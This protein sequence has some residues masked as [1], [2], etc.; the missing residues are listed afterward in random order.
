MESID[1]TKHGL[2]ARLPRTETDGG[3]CALK[4]HAPLRQAVERYHEV[5]AQCEARMASSTGMDPAFQSLDRERRQAI[6]AIM[7]IDAFGPEGVKAKLEVLRS[8]HGWCGPDESVVPLAMH[9][10]EEAVAYLVHE[11]GLLDKRAGSSGGWT[12]PGRWPM[13]A[14]ASVPAFIVDRFGL[15]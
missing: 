1:S 9:V 11:N 4:V 6:Q 5:R 14:A 10:A 7:E 2:E 8:V 3:N 15:G 12:G 13:G